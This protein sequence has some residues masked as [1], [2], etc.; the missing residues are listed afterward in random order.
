[1]GRI[2]TRLVIL[3]TCAELILMLA[4][5]LA[6]LA[7]AQETAQDTGSEPVQ[8][9]GQE[10]YAP[11]PVPDRIVLTFADDPATTQSVTWRTDNRLAAFVEFA[12]AEDGPKFVRNLKRVTATSSEFEANRTKSFYHSATMTDLEPETTY[13]YRV[14]DG[15][16]WSEFSHFTT[17]SADSKPFS[18]IYFGDAQNDIKSHWARVV[19]QSYRQAPNAAFMLHAGDLVNVANNDNEWGQWFYSGGWLFRT[20]PSIATPGNHEYSREG[21]SKHWRTVFALPENGPEALAETVYWVRL[22][23]CSV[24]FVEHESVHR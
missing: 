24:Y 23:G 2:L 22:P 7:D 21:L 14:G 1:M 13:A 12:Q 16:N 6:T 8:Y 3:M 15:V 20:L 9:P 5:A 17:A 18:F 10:L 11:T 4:F 19:R